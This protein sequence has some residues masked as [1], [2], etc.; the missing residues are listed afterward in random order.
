MTW[1]AALDVDGGWLGLLLFAAASRRL[2]HRDQWI[3]WSEEQRRRL[4]LV[5][6]N[7]RFLLLPDKTTPNLGSAVLSRVAARLSRAW[8]ERYAHPVL[9]VE[10]PNTSPPPTSAA[11]WPP[12][13]TAPP[14]P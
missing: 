10:N 1:Y 4:P 6:N 12:I 14:S 11:S 3:G 13:M 9:V 2:R 5:V 8:M 7:T